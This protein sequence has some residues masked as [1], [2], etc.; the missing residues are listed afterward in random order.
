[1]SE[2]NREYSL[3]ELE[4]VTHLLNG[5]F[6]Q[7]VNN[8]ETLQDILGAHPWLSPII[9][10]LHEDETMCAFA[11]TWEE[12]KWPIAEVEPEP[13]VAVTVSFPIGLANRV[14]WIAAKVQRFSFAKT[15][16]G[17]VPAF[18]SWGYW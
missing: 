8:P 5:V 7:E 18:S 3:L 2:N 16:A 15:P 11:S 1:M 17:Y 14:S 6:S 12:R 10:Q 4:G 9:E 13:L